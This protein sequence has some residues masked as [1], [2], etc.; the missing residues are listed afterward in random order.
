MRGGGRESIYAQKLRR[1]AIECVA[2][3]I[4]ALY[5]LANSN[6]NVY[7]ECILDEVQTISMAKTKS[8]AVNALHQIVVPT[9]EY[10]QAHQ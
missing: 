10:V 7:I 3:K 8:S 4:I 5:K 6:T 1:T 9:T 2:H